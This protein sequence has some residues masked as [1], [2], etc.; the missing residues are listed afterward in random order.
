MQKLKK[1]LKSVTIDLKKL[2]KKTDMMLKKVEKLEKKLSTKKPKRKTKAKAKASVAKK[3]VKK[4]AGRVTATG[5]VLSIIEGRKKGINTAQLQ[6]KTGFDERKI[7]NII[8]I[9]KRQGKVKSE[10]P[11][12]YVKA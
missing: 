12:V 3:A 8:N 9:L 7:W 1:D 4:K 2:T 11:G 10:K 5:T 6:A